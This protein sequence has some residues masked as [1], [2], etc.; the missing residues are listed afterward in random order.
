M[1]RAVVLF[2]AWVEQRINDNYGSK[3][4]LLGSAVTVICYAL[5]TAKL[6]I[7]NLMD[8]CRGLVSFYLPT[9][10]KLHNQTGLI[11]CLIPC[12]WKV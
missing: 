5:H 2:P 1:I 9:D 7:S 6:V 10:E 12:K 4:V 11:I 3:F 8:V